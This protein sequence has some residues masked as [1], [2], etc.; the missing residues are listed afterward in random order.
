MTQTVCLRPSGI[1][2]RMNRS[3]SSL[4]IH[5]EARFLEIAALAI[6]P[7][8]GCGV[9]SGKGFKTGQKPAPDT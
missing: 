5:P 7:Q 1:S 4:E 8:N 2:D 6:A 3:A 9:V